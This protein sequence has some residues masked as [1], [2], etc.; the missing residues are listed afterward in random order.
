MSKTPTASASKPRRPVGRPRGDGKPHLTRQRVFEACTRLIAQHGFAGASIRMMANALEAS[1]AS[2]F[3]LFGSKDG[4]LNELI[5]YAAQPSLTFYQA[6]LEV[7]VAPEIQ[8]YKSIYEEVVAVASADRD[9]VG[10]FYLPE[11]RKPQF[12]SAQAVR[13]RMVAHYAK[14]IER[15]VETGVVETVSV[16]LSAEQIFQL[17]ETSILAPQ[18]S[19]TLPPKAQAKETAEFC[20]RALCFDQHRL[21]AIQNAAAKIELSIELPSA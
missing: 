2:L 20:L 3:N 19:S 9:F 11:L 17:T 5:D 7:D 16:E 15:C 18:L 12:E 13:A 8:L 10:I 4:L 6:L 14:L 21:G 1:P